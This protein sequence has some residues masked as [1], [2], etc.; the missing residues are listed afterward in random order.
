GRS[1]TPPTAP[2]SVT[3]SPSRTQVI[4]SAIT[5]NQCHRLHGNRSRRAGMSLST[6]AGLAIVPTPVKMGQKTRGMYLYQPFHT[7]PADQE[8]RLLQFNFAYGKRV[9]VERSGYADLDV[10]V[11]FQFCDKL[12]CLFIARV[13]ELDDLLVVSENAVAALHTVRH[14]Q[15]PL[16]VLG[17]KARLLALLGG[18]R[19]VNQMALYGGVGG[20]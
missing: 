9:T 13:I 6:S 3:S 7:E 10:L 17:A 16:G 20:K 15:T 5:T 11:L 18:A 14:F 2:A 8:L 19:Q 4:P 1:S 12:F